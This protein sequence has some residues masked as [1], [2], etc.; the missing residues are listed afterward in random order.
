MISVIVP[1]KN[2][3]D[4]LRVCLDSIYTSI[5]HAHN[6]H[7]NLDIEVIVVNDNSDIGFREKIEARYDD[8][9]V[10]DSSGIGPGY[11]RN[12]G[13]KKSKGKYLFFTDSDCIVDEAWIIS[14]YSVLLNKKAMVVQG[15][16]WLFQKKANPIYGIYEEKLYEIMFSKYV[17]G[18]NTTMTDSRNLLLDKN[19]VSIIGAEVF[20]EKA[21]KATAE[22]RVFGKRCISNGINVFFSK[23]VRIYH[24]DPHNLEDVCRQK[25]RHGSGRVL[26]W[27]KKQ[28]YSYLRNRYFS[29]PISEG[30]PVDYVLPA[31]AAFLFGFYN[32][33]NDLTERNI[34]LDFLHRVFKSYDRSLLDYKELIGYLQYE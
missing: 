25:Y 18:S 30:L 15:I 28:D 23:D 16:P 27:E 26:I 19:V 14:G 21:E 24:E 12:L 3:I 1:C 31:H 34:F 29:I 33:I 32:N 20:S 9:T 13:I 5:A 6:N 10:L 11:A 7:P 8:I 17:N 22:S 2:R 4:Q